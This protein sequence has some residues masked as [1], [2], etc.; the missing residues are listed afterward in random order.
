MSAPG[1]GGEPPRNHEAV[2]AELG[3]LRIVP[4]VVIKDADR[5]VPLAQALVDG[6]LPCVEITFRTAAAPEAL[7][8]IA[9]ELPNVFVGAGTVL[10]PEQAALARDAGASFVVS[11][12]FN[13]RVVDYCLD[14]G[15]P[16]YP[17]VCTP[18]EIEAALEKGLQVLKFF[19]AEPMGGARFLSSISAPFPGLKFIPTGG[20]GVD[21]LSSYLKLDQ[22]VACGGSW[23][24]S[25]TWIDAGDFER[26]RHETRQAVEAAARTRP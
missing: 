6:G 21:Q 13:P 23:M 10:T 20:V 17:G 2:T 19:P 22:V 7:R 4:V 18:T 12:G 3:R 1:S 5:A 16:I 15:I 24:A 25:G 9:A 8:R 11:P 26:I 14:Q